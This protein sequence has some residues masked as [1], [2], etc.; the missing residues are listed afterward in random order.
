MDAFRLIAKRKIDEGVARGEFDNLPLAGKRIDLFEDAHLP[1]ELRMAWRILKNAGVA[2]EEVQLLKAMQELREEL[3]GCED[4]AR[5][6]ALTRE[7][8]DKEAQLNILLERRRL[9]R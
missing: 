4:E 7:L 3:G 8:R 1:P 5:R 6:E 2:P 9:A